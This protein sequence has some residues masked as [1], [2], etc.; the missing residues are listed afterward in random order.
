MI[1]G[2]CLAG[3]KE[4]HL[5]EDA[6]CTPAVFSER[7]MPVKRRRRFK[8]TT[9]FKDRLVSWAEAIRTDA[10]KLAPGPEKEELLKKLGQADVATDFDEWANSAGVEAPPGSSKERR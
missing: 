3:N 4:V 7:A 10:E 5:W 8:Q 9:T 6:G 2:E 1:S